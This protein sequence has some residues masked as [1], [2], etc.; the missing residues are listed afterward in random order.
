MLVMYISVLAVNV[1]VYVRG[2]CTAVVQIKAVRSSAGLGI[3][4][5]TARVHNLQ[6]LTFCT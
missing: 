6:N 4:Y 1:Y 5:Q 3:K 2:P